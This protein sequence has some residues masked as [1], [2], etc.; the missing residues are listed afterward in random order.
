M[1][2]GLPRGNRL[3]R[4]GRLSRRWLRCGLLRKSA[5]GGAGL[6]RRCRRVR[7]GRGVGGRDDLGRLRA[8]RLCLL[9][10]GSVLRTRLL[11]RLCRLVLRR[12]VLC[13]RILLRLARRGLT[14]LRLAGLRG[15]AGLRLAG[16][17]LARLSARDRCDHLGRVRLA[18][19]LL[20]VL[21]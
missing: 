6:S 7:V 19:C 21:G 17:G 20:G 16:L 1:L 12:L 3:S 13:G 4:L 2:R 15:L 5:R 10:P 14:G 9:L 11:C 8:A 18:R